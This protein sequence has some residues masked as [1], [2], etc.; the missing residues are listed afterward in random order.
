VR[1]IGRV[2]FAVGVLALVALGALVWRR[3]AAP[4]SP[5]GR[6]QNTEPA[7]PSGSG[8][9]LILQIDRTTSTNVSAGTPFFFT[10]TVTGP[11]RD[12]WSSA[13]RFETA[14][15]RKLPFRIDRLGTPFRVEIGNR[16]AADARP[17]QARDEP[18]EV[19]Q[20]EFSVSPE[21]SARLS[22]GT[23]TIRAVMA[24]AGSDSDSRPRVSN[25]VTLNVASPASSDGEKAQLETVA[26]FNLR[27][28]RWDEAH[29]AA[30]RLVGRDDA[31][32]TAYILLGDALNGLRRDEEALAAYQ[33]ALA[34]LPKEL[35]ESPD[36]LLARM[37]EVQ[38]RLEA[39]A[40]RKQP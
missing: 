14:D 13:L 2:G 20:A 28:K 5:P 30:L 8:P 4:A 6:S 23:Y 17:E 9:E 10:V 29:R 16:K 18:T 32:A 11:S 25:L 22:T 37:E 26:R 27:S 34:A 31:D 15:G 40:A 19:H 35:H 38:E 24:Q 3:S 33:E 1:R 39:A 7:A 36:Y 12:A 21:E